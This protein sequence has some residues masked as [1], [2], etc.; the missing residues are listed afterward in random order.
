MNKL[1][2]V[3]DDK[4]PLNNVIS[5]LSIDVDEV[6]YVYHHSYSESVFNNIKR[7]INKYKNINLSFI[8]IKD[9]E[10]EIKEL[11][12]KDT[13]IDVGGAKYLSLLMFDL[14]L[15]K[16]N[17]II[18]YD[19]EENTIKDYRS[20]KVLIKDVFKLDI[21]DI[22]RLRGGEIKSQLH[23]NVND[24]ESKHVVVKVFEDNLHDYNE[25]IKYLTIVNS[26]ISDNNYLGNNEYA[27]NTD[28]FKQFSKLNRF[29][30]VDE[31][32]ELKDNKIIF[33]SRKFKELVSVSGAILENYIYIKLKEANYFDDIRMSTVIDFSDDKYIYPVR[34]E[35]D[36]LLIKNNHLLFVS[37]KSSKAATDDLNEIFVHNKMFGNCLSKPVMVVGEELDRKYPSIYAKGEE[38]EIFLVDKSCFLENNVA[39]VFQNI[40]EG[41]YKYDEII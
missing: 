17:K 35:I 31:L 15:K 26:K 9:D 36:C 7:V 1:L 33:K 13:I 11:I 5:A 3:Y 22:L 10:K 16:K 27:I 20:H 18:Y 30:N 23:K 6:F 37:C 32:F 34:C 19:D 8:E 29:N 2:T 12:D 4:E 24:E 39:K 38:L 41:N 28:D 25:F 14:V 40:I 21:D